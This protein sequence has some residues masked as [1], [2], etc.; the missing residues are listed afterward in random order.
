[1]SFFSRKPEV[2]LEEF[3]RDFYENQILNPVI[4]GVDVGNTYLNQVKK[5]VAEAD[6]KFNK[7]DKEKLHKEL[8]ILRFELLALA[9]THKFISG[10]NVIVQSAFTKR[11]LIRKKRDDIWK[12]MDEYS[13]MIDGA[14]LH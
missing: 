8:T 9:W 11:Y 3:C 2:S 14:T 12:E 13:K 5:T 4:G 7:V 1:M 6:P 10:K